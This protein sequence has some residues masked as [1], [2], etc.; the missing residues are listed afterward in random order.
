[1]S[2]PATAKQEKTPP[3]SKKG[4]FMGIAGLVVALAGG[5]YW[6][7]ASAGAAKA[8]EAAAGEGS[9]SE[10]AADDGERGLLALDPFVVNLVDEGGS[11]FLRTNI[12]LIIAATEVEATEIQEKKVEMMPI[13]SAVLELLAQQ[14]AAALVTPAGKEALK[15]AIKT[16]AGEVFRKHK[17]SDVLFTEF[18]VQF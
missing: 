13:R 8:A 7:T 6:Y 14:S 18:V 2:T 5:G 16:R 17:I 1:M 10:H 15:A 11:H 3:T 12:Q 9:G 4:L